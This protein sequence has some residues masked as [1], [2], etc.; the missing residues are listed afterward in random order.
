MTVFDRARGKFDRARPGLRSVLTMFEVYFDFFCS[1]RTPVSTI[2]FW[3]SID[4]C[5]NLKVKT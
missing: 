2:L 1:T 4:M 5:S 3:S